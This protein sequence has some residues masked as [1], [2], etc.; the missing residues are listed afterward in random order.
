MQ[1]PVRVAKSKAHRAG[2]SITP[3]FTPS[4]KAGMPW[5]W[6]TYPEFLDSIERG[7]KGVWMEPLLPG[8]AE[9]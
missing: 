5:D 6:V 4:M 1:A 8:K 2:F 3:S 9:E 7:R